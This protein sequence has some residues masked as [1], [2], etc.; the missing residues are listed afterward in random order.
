MIRI[1]RYYANNV[2]EMPVIESDSG[3]LCICFV[4]DTEEYFI[5]VGETKEWVQIEFMYQLCNNISRI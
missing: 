4:G 5:W 3:V 1:H 2:F